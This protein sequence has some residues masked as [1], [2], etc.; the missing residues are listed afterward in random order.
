MTLWPLLYM[1]A[2]TYFFAKSWIDQ[3][4]TIFSPVVIALHVLALLTNVTLLVIY[5]RDVFRRDLPEQQQAI[6]GVA[7]GLLGPLAMLP[8]WWRFIGPAGASS[9]SRPGAENAP[10]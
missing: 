10:G 7:M 6:W 2:F 1:G 3:D 5:V 9:P 8:Y 4:E